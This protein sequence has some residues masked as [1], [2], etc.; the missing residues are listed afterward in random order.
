M[1]A[2]HGFDA[3]GLEISSTAVATAKAYAASEMTQPSAHN[4]SS[5]ANGPQETAG[6]VTFLHGDFFQS[7]WEDGMILNASLKFDLIYDYTVKVF[8]GS[9]ILKI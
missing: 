4:F 9:R 1:L 8:P 6:P 3:Y 5:T 7:D 2:L